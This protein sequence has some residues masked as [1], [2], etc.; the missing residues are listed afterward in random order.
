V[1]TTRTQRRLL[2][3]AATAIGFAAA[4]TYVVVIALPEMMDA[5][6]LSVTQLQRAAPIISGFL[7]GYVAMLPLIGRLA[8]LRGRIPVL[9]ACLVIFL[10]GSLVTA[11]GY[12]LLW[13]VAGRF[14]QGIGAGGLIPPTLALV[15]ET[16][17]AERRGMPLGAI[18]AVQELGSVL[19]PLYG[20]AVLAVGDWRAIFVTNAV[21]AA[22]LATAV[23]ML[24]GSGAERVRAP[25]DLAGGL[26]LGLACTG[27]GLI[28]T[29]PHSLSSGLTTGLAFEP[30]W[31]ES[32]WLT[33]LG[34]VVLGALVLFV[35]RQATAR[36]PLVRIDGWRAQAGELDLLG[37]GLL[38]L[39]LGAVVLA[40]AS[41]EPEKALVAAGAGW[42][43]PIA[44]VSGA[45]FVWR[46]RGAAHPLI[47]RGTLAARPAWGALAVSFFV[48]VALIA[49]LVDVPLFARL[50]I[51]PDSQLDAALVLLRFLVA[52]PVGAVGGGWLLRRGSAAAIAGAGMMLASLGFLLMA[53][54]PH[55][56]VNS[57][58]A[59]L[60]LLVTGL[61]F[62]LTLA[63]VNAALLAHTSAEAHSVAS[64]LLIVSRMVGMLVGIS[65]LTA[66]GVWAF[67][68]AVDQIPPIRQLCHGP[69]TCR[70]YSAAVLEA[71]LDQLRAVFAGACAAS[72]VAATLAALLLRDTAE[73]NR[74]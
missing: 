35:A 60:A 68:D 58:V 49:A 34:A 55:G 15:A 10:L 32:R 74:R 57:P 39:T 36:R 33:P 28:L 27:V 72:A 70:A 9:L 46:Q 6:G 61:G 52:V 3:V 45:L 31:G 4:D 69:L 47:P 2:A 5:S 8:D 17:P 44:A 54:W 64:A 22:V 50:T 30:L 71:G 53:Q 38:T 21:I 14:I 48:G 59:T 66:V 26:L 37:G 12:D 29:R 1:S 41:A 43:L 51:Y 24:R 62:G 18:G 73:T 40:F 19:G 25:R 63:P 65:M 42:L 20:A 16:W 67:T 56:A 13:V 11:A 23:L 7:L